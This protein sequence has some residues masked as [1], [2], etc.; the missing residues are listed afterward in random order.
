MN[1]SPTLDTIGLTRH[2]NLDAVRSRAPL[3]VSFCGGGTDVPP[4]PERFGGCVLSCTIDKYAY[5]SC[6]D[7]HDAIVRVHS[8]DLNKVLEFSSKG[9]G[10]PRGE[11]RV[12]EAIIDR[13]GTTSLDCYMHSD[14]PP[15]SGL[16][17]SSAMLVS[18]IAALARFQNVDLQPYEIA[19]LA[20]AVERTDLGISGGMQDQYAATFG[21]FN[22]IE[23]NSDGV[24]VNPL[25]LRESVLEELHYHL[26]LCYTGGTRLSSD[27]LEEQT[28]RVTASENVVV[29]ALAEMK[30]LTIAMKRA[31]LHERLRDFGE[32]LHQAWLL[33]RQLAS[34]ISNANIETLYEAARASGAIGGKLLGAGG[35]GFL[36]LFVPF[37]RRPHVRARLEELG[38]RIVDFQFD[39]RGVRTWTTSAETWT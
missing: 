19:E 8:L 5:V 4:Y 38:G 32:L 22:F 26:L 33:K 3:R 21:G 16:G 27:I 24:L 13:F 30:Q 2:R 9:E 6:R 23:F 1:A 20:Y 14:A 31:L 39:H 29:D 37:T 12:A 36:L 10:R 25:R 28:A 11:I 35:G 18:L 7:L 17:S 34:G 15:G